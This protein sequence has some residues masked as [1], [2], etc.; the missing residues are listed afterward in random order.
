[1]H[2][3]TIKKFDPLTFLRKLDTVHQNPCLTWS[4]GQH[5]WK[6]ILAFDPADS[7]EFK[8][9]KNLSEFYRFAERHKTRLL[10]GYV[11]YDLG[12]EL[13]Q[14]DPKTNF[15]PDV[16]LIRFFAFDNYIIC[17]ESE[18]KLYYRDTHF[19][20]LVRKIM[21]APSPPEKTDYHYRMG[22]TLDLEEYRVNFEK[23]KEYIKAGDIYQIN[24]TH[25]MRGES[26]LSGSE[27]F[28]KFVR[29]NPAQFA[30]FLGANDFDIVSIS[31]ES[32][33]QVKDNRIQTHPIKGTRPRGKDQKE[34]LMMREAML[35]SEKEQAELFM[36]VDLLRND[37]GKVCE[38]GSVKVEDPRAVRKLPTVWHTH[39][40]ISGKLKKGYNPLEALISMFPGGSITGCPKK[41]AMEI[42]DELESFHRGIYTGSIGYLFPDGEMEFNI[43]IRTVLHKQG[44]LYLGVG[45]GITIDSEVEDEYKETFA[46]AKA[47]ITL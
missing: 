17:E 45:G 31:P 15:D 29:K 8:G 5:G 26:D 2:H 37:L 19:P 16:P 12:Y 38:T 18:G 39:A 44:K 28:E 10:M 40:T 24:Y 4:D 22:S 11:S 27:L 14:I 20:E 34:D 30:A 13:L 7:F 36:I 42:I 21:S 3:K 33:I 35:K 1:M 25:Q 9:G 32:F 47:F 23:I 43:S 46:K 6:Q 41:R